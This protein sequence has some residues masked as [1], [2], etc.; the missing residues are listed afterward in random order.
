MGLSWVIDS[1]APLDGVVFASKR[2]PE[3]FEAPPFAGS[4][5][6]LDAETTV[7]ISPPDWRPVSISRL[8]TALAASRGPLQAGFWSAPDG[9][10]PQEVQFK[11]LEEL[12][13]FARRVFVAAGAGMDSSGETEPVIIPL[14]PEAPSGWQDL[15]EELTRL[16]P[17]ADR[18][19]LVDRLVKAVDAE[20]LARALAISLP[21][22]TNPWLTPQPHQ[23]HRV[24][25]YLDLH[26]VSGPY[27]A[28]EPL[29]EYSFPFVPASWM[30]RDH[31][32][33]PAARAL[34]L[35]FRVP[36]IL[37]GEKPLP[38]R[39]LGDQL[40]LALASRRRI[41]SLKT[42]HEWMP[43]TVAALL[44]ASTSSTALPFAHVARLEYLLI[45]AV[46]WLVDVLPDTSLQ[47]HEDVLE[48]V[49][50]QIEEHR[51]MRRP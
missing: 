34:S 45:D 42:P 23:T 15:L 51:F 17:E 46:R 19:H 37:V 40:V 39:T 44:I 33:L 18:R 20:G 28:H 4:P 8:A 21:A 22:A 5:A 38:G 12:I 9:R 6:W 48:E 35:L 3:P 36:A 16:Q 27:L 43:L 31:S 30:A 41:A 24:R 2:K 49:L 11:N 14:T 10:T 13:E 26:G 7:H 29:Y 1:W 50:A 32:A 25:D 47:A